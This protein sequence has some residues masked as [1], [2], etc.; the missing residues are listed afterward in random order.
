MLHPSDPGSWYN[1]L[2]FFLHHDT[3]PYH[4]SYK[5]KCAFILKYSRYQ[6]INGVL[7][8]KNHEGILFRCLEKSDAKKVLKDLHDGPTSGHFSRDTTA[9]NILRSGYY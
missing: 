7:F 4:M 6:L 5:S 2:K 1:D 3:F 8:Q 9:R